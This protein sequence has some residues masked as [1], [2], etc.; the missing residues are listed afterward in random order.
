MMKLE[1]LAVLLTII[2]TASS[3]IHQGKSFHT[4]SINMIMIG[5]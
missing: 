2:D 5:S 3:D 1:V 4:V